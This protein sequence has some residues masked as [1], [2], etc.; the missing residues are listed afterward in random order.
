MQEKI[1]I[2]EYADNIAKAIQALM[3]SRNYIVQFLAMSSTDFPTMYDAFPDLLR[4]EKNRT[5]LEMA[6]G[7]SFGERVEVRDYEKLGNILID[8]Y[9]RIFKA[10]EKEDVAQGL[11]QLIENDIKNIPA[12]REEWLESRLHGLGMEPNY[13]QEAVNVLR[14]IKK[15][16]EEK[17]KQYPTYEASSARIAKMGNVTESRIHYVID[18]LL[19]YKLVEKVNVAEEGQKKEGIR[20]RDSLK[21]YADMIDTVFK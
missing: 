18:L 20:F 3:P 10:L 7:V 5:A 21:D 9:S 8:F 6:F 15:I 2:K 12:P 4:D 1:E 11:A 13:G 16:G 14:A 17:N 19:K